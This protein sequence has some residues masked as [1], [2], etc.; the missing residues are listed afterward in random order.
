MINA[1]HILFGKHFG[2]CAVELLCR[3]Q[4]VA[5]GLFDNDPRPT[6]F[7]VIQTGLAQSMDNFSEYRCRSREIEQKIRARAFRLHPGEMSSQL[8]VRL[9]VAGIGAEV[10]DA[11]GKVSPAFG[12]E[13]A[14]V[15]GMRCSFFEA[16]AEVLVRQLFSADADNVEVRRHAAHAGKVVESGNQLAPGE[17]AARA[18]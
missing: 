2:E 7:A 15:F 11:F 12:A 14:R 3:L 10:C 8:V 4:V 5:K 17:V 16:A 1:I 13:V 18:E 6:L 9:W